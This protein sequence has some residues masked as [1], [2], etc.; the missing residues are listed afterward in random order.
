MVF[1]VV[2]QT[3]SRHVGMQV[4]SRLSLISCVVCIV[5][6]TL[7][8]RNDHALCNHVPLSLFVMSWHAVD[9]LL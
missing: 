7:F 5:I 6:V 1:F 8:I 9:L 2:I 4:H 3:W